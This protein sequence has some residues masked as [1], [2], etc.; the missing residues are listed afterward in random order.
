M[1]YD[2]NQY[3]VREYEKLDS[4]LEQREFVEKMRFLMM[5]KEKTFPAIIP[6]GTWQDGNSIP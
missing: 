5:A 6:D 3:L 2:L 4:E 1:S